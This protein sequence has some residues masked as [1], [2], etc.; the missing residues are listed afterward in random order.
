MNTD[1]PSHTLAYSNLIE[2]VTDELEIE[3]INDDQLAAI[4][5]TSGKTGNPKGVM[6]THKSLYANAKMQKNSIDIPSGVIGISVLPLCHSYGIA[7]MNFG[8][9]I[10]GGRSVLLSSFDIDAIFFAIEK[11]NG[12]VMGAIP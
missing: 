8:A 3:A 9:L 4:I 10:G 5:Y 6:H 1:V 11:Y 2:S 12:F 7:N